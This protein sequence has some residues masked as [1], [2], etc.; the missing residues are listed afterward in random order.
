MRSSA[1]YSYDQAFYKNKIGVY[2][3]APGEWSLLIKSGLQSI[4]LAKRIINFLIKRNIY[5]LILILFFKL[6]LFKL[7]K[8]S[9]HY[10]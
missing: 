6:Y 2:F 8:G 5:L 3:G 1:N 9:G 10:W 7:F 4:C